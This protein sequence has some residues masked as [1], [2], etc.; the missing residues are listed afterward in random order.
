MSFQAMPSF[1]KQFAQCTPGLG[2]SLFR[3]TTRKALHKPV[4]RAYY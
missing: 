2:K 4:I 3:A 1:T